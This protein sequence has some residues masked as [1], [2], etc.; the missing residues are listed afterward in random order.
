MSRSRVYYAGQSVVSMLVCSDG[1]LLMIAQAYIW[2]F[3]ARV[4]H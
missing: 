3:G 1:V 2:T 4:V